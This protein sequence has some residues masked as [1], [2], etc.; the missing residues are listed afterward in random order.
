M[1]LKHHALLT[2]ISAAAGVLLSLSVY[3]DDNSMP[4]MPGMEMPVAIPVLPEMS[5][6]DSIIM[7]PEMADSLERVR[8]QNAFDNAVALHEKVRTLRS[9]GEASET[10][11]PQVYTCYSTNVETLDLFEPGQTEYVRIK[12]I[13]RDIHR[14]LEEGAFFY[15]GKNNSAEMVKF[16][17]AFVDTKLMPQFADDNLPVNESY[18]PSLV[19]CAA[20]GAYNEKDYEGAIKYFKEYFST[21]D[22]RYREQIYIFMGQAC[23]NSGNYPLA[24]TTLRE[25]AKQFPQNYSILQLAIQACIDGGM[26]E[27][28]QDFLD[29]ALALKPTDETLLNIQGK[30]Y[31]DQGE[32]QKA[33]DLFNRLDMLHP[34]NLSITK[35]IGLCY[36]NI[37]SNYTNM[38]VGETDEKAEKK[39]RRQAKNYFSDAVSK[40]SQV[41]AS[42]PTAVKYL[43][44]LAVSY[45]FLDNKPMFM[46]VNTRLQAL[47]E[48][49]LDEMYMPP[50]VGYNEKGGRNYEQ[51][52][53]SLLATED[54]PTYSQYAK[55]IIEEGLAKW[56][57]RGEFEKLEDYQKRV[58]DKTILAEYERI[59]AQTQKDYLEQFGH[60]LRINDL[61]LQPYDANNEVYKIESE[62]GQILINVPLKNNEA[63]LFQA[64][65]ANTHFKAPKFYIKDDRVQLSSITF[66]TPTNKTYTFNSNDD[67]AYSNTHVDIDFD[68]I[69]RAANNDVAS[70]DTSSGK[71]VRITLKS[72]VDTDIPETNKI[73]ANTVAVIIANEDYVNVSKVRSALNDGEAFKL[74]CNKT[75]GI[76]DQNIRFYSNATLGTMLRSVADLRHTTD[77]LG[78][79]SDVIFYYAG[80]GMPDESTHDAFLLPVDADGMV[81]ESCYP[82]SK[83][84][85]ELANLNASSVMVFLDACFSGAQ[86]DGGM[87]MAARG[88]AIKP[89]TTAPAGNMFVLSAASDKETALPY[90][91]KNHGMFTY[92]LL[93]KLQETK[94]NTTLKGLSDYVIEK[95][96]IQSNLI[97]KK[98]QTPSVS[99]SGTMTRNY[100]KKK[101]RP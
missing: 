40:L 72:D 98:P 25:G 51:A 45:L 8:R 90:E 18:Y 36:Y 68:A 97:N 71:G 101:L 14:M 92:Y 73:A 27:Y 42:D 63:E 76:P 24:V 77:A 79:D 28:M 64:N 60:K 49:P 67:I 31:E 95:V 91:E 99:T 75:L 32:Y 96:K 93:K 66:V 74:Y 15:S 52:G 85:K 84:Y 50:T 34:D 55:P 5:P 38:A 4:E 7:T 56:T 3:A 35:H 80:H 16:A 54:T 57:R 78:A 33:L 58:N 70:N 100:L 46:E 9:E 83:L 21:G 81:T 12:S 23:L 17:R 41:T 19:Y 89:K 26:A 37:A 6:V 20:S 53:N 82:L 11:F 13:L 39:Y 29:Q 43:K 1:K 65:W 22:P 30:L 48:D 62:Y 10:F 59:S 86:R 94:G 61:K 2:G 47:G 44:A 88:V 87:L 69:I